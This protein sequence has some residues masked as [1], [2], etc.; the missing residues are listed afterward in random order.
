MFHNVEQNT[1]EWFQLRAGKLTGSSIGVVMANYGK[2]FGNPAKQLAVNIAVEQIKGEPLV[3]DYTNEHMERGHAEEPIARDL[4]EQT[5]FT[6]ITNGGFFDNGFTGCSPDGLIDTEGLVEI[7]SAIPH[8][9][10]SRI[11]RQ[12]LD[13]AYRW[14]CVNNLR[15][16][17]REWLDFISYCSTFP[18]EWQLYICRL[19]AEQCAEDFKKLESRIGE[20]EWL[21]AEVVG[22]IKKSNYV[23][24]AA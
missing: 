1:E 22:D 8:I 15:E 6:T 17:K 24:R 13:P 23:T 11:K 16:T 7:K 10:Y 21:V 20:F 19:H 3:S 18:D 12:G 14:Q 4:Y 9:H 2:A 5:F